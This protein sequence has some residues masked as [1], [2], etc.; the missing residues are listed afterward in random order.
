MSSPPTTTEAPSAAAAEA[1]VD[2]GI[3]PASHWQHATEEEDD[4]DTDADSTT[5]QSVSSSTDSLRSSI[6]EYRKINGR[7]FHRDA[8]YWASNDEK[9]SESLDINHHALTLACDGKLHLA[10]LEKDKI[11]ARIWAIDFADEYPGAEVIGTDI[12]PIQS[13]WVPPNLR[14]EIDDCTREWTFAPDSVDYIHMRWLI[15]SISR[16]DDLFTQAYRCC[17]PGGWVESFEPSPFIT[18]DDGSVKEDSAMGQWGKFFIKGG[19]QFGLGFTIAEEDK[20]KKAMEA[21]GFVDV[22]EFNFKTPLGRWPKEERLK[23][24]GEYGSLVMLSDTEGSVLFMASTLG[25]SEAEIHVYIAHL[26]REIQSGRYHPF[27][28]QKVVWGRKPA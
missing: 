19:K 3:L 27:Y 22:Q 28:R 15:G 1:A 5:G 20:Q 16:W 7:T 8:H 9:Q 25:W 10:P 23:E 21:A 4:Q 14:F 2:D 12:S 24:L 13:S 17:R 18:S 11:L 26:R 6:Y